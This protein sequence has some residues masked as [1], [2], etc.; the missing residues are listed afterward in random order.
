[1][2]PFDSRTTTSVY[3]HTAPV[4][5]SGTNPPK[6]FNTVAMIT[7]ARFAASLSVPNHAESAVPIA[8]VLVAV[9]E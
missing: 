9:V 5:I 1:M 3:A 6:R 8:V 7:P 4:P 2:F